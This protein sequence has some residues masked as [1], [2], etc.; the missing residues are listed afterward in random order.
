[1][2]G[3]MP[4]R[5]ASFFRNL[6]RK[7]AVE[8]ALDDELQS[9]VELLTQEKMKQGL[10][11]PE[12]RRQALIELGGVEQVKEEVRAIRSGVF[13]ETF[14]QDLRYGLRILR[15]SPGFTAVAVLTLALGIGANTAIFSL[16]NAAFF[17][18]LPY[19]RAERLAFLWQDNQRTGES[20]GTVSYPNYADWSTQSQSFDEMAFI[21]SGDVLLA[22]GGTLQHVPAV[23]V[24]TNF[25]SV[26]GVSP[27]LGRDFTFSDALGPTYGAIIGY[28][29]WQ[30]YYGGDPNIIGRLAGSGSAA[31][32]TIIG[33]MPQGFSFPPGTEIWKPRGV[34][35]YL[36][37]QSRPYP[38]FK[39]IGRLHAGV[40]WS[41]AQAEMD[42]IAN[43]LAARYPASDDGVGIRVVSL[44]EQL[45]QSVRQGLL[46]LWA[47]IAGVLL[48][49]CV[50]VANLMMARAASHQEEIAVR[51]SFGATRARIA[52]QFLAESFLLAAAGA[53]AGFFLAIWTV[54]S[55]SKLNPDIARL[56]VSVLDARVL[57][58]T[59]AVA[60]FTVLVCAIIPAFSA[61]RVDLN[62]ALKETSSAASPGAQL[63]RKLLIIAEVSLAFILLAGSGLLIRS[64]WQVLS[65]NPGLD[66]NHVLEL[67]LR[68]P[69]SYE[70]PEESKLNAVYCGLV[71]R[72]R[73]LPGVVSVGA[74]SK[75][76]FP[77]N[78]FRASFVIEGQPTSPGQ[79]PFLPR[80][81]AT[82]DYFRTV[83]IPLLRG[84][85][86]TNA[87]T[88]ENT[89]PV[90]IINA[91]M[92]KR[93]W[94]NADPIGKALK[95]D[96]PTLKN[97][98][99][100]IVGVVGDV[101]QQGFENSA[102][103]MAYFPSAGHWAGDVVIRTTGNPT[104]LMPE[105]LDEVRTVSSNFGI[106]SLAPL[107][108]I[109]SAHESQRKFN[110]WLLGA[111]AFIALLL[112]VVGIY[113]SVSYW[114]KQRTREIGVRMALGA[115]PQNI[116]TLIIG[117]GMAIIFV[118]L[119]FGIA[120]ALALTRFIAS[121]LFGVR[122]E[123]PVTYAAV[124]LLFAMVALAASYIP[125]RRAMR[126]DPV[127]ALRYE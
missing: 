42:T 36:R 17:R 15:K 9:A 32:T 48:I 33:V 1:M 106:D 61:S 21:G 16:A 38:F 89:Q 34:D 75:V 95:V 126:V 103:L 31:N 52:R 65:V 83:G 10:S 29:V 55:V 119:A 109:L 116:L 104:A 105:V 102:G 24:S 69:W 37:T 125:A 88:A 50:N 56:G 4:G 44:R 74:T 101:R 30:S 19:P 79:R 81:E 49:A 111:L 28:N 51:F 18:A 117:R 39:V 25:L 60:A 98:W 122:P 94:P 45:S 108:S 99:F 7:R 6:L 67:N 20:E 72:L 57:L 26:L 46:L 62:R 13:L 66:A 78:M 54:A 82:P 107:S 124:M 112:A 93:Y 23:D 77:D 118:G 110:A 115:Q 40:K 92:A 63:I 70:W 100:S 5:I 76:L 8:Q 41:S 113:G 27:L 97:S 12:A 96:D 59:I 84:R 11:H 2:G 73:A 53:I 85:V 86:F 121:M 68:V 120:G 47:A 90:T 22:K 58:Y 91:T 14:A 127:V 114:V 3:V 80:A 87:D 71:G 43:R 35:E 123:D 64:L